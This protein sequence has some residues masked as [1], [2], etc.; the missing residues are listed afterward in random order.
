MLYNDGLDTSK[1]FE[2]VDL[3]DM[4]IMKFFYNRLSFCYDLK[5]L[6]NYDDDKSFLLLDFTL[7][8]WML[9]LLLII[10]NFT[11]PLAFSCISPF[12]NT[13]AFTKGLSLTECGI[14]FAIFN[15]LGIF[16]SPVIGA[17]I[18]KIGLKILL[19]SGMITISVGTLLF[20]ITTKIQSRSWFFV[21]SLILRLIQSLGYSILSTSSFACVS[22]SFPDL[23]STILG[24]IETFVG[25]GFTLGPFIG[26]LL[27]DA[28]GYYLPFTILGVILLICGILSIFLIKVD[29]EDSFIRIHYTFY[30]KLLKIPAVWIIMGSAISA[31][32]VFQYHDVTLPEILK[33]FNLT[34]SQI[35]SFFLLMGVP[36]AIL[37]PL[38]GFILDKYGGGSYFIISGSILSVV[39]FYCFGPAPFIPF[40]RNLATLIIMSIFEGISVGGLYI[41]CFSKSLKTL[42]KENDFP[43]NLETSS[44]VSG[45]FGMCY[46]IG[47]VIGP[48]G[49][50]F[51]VDQLDYEWS[52]FIYGT[53]MLIYL[54]IFIF[55]YCI[56]RN[57]R[58]NKVKNIEENLSTI[59]NE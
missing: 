45:I 57:L 5:F 42:I 18:P 9:L 27:Y 56:P 25:L 43:E 13:V 48:S 29:K 53:G 38:Y 39:S 8:N 52:T 6:R 33:E 28:G 49:G 34:S 24:M 20:A 58:K 3:L 59:A 19:S 4:N 11:C 44:L 54:F 17:I 47:A 51:L 40:K 37:T 50:S 22:R 1:S 36:Y 35:G 31:G 32:I 14:V 23:T 12:Y 26:G 15:F 7:L 21:V 30:Y 10:S 2:S 16:A 41:P 46:S 55:F